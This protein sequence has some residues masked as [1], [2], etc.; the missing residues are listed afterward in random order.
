MTNPIIAAQLPTGRAPA[1]LLVQRNEAGPVTYAA[2]HCDP[3]TAIDMLR[4]ALIHVVAEHHAL[5]TVPADAVIL[6]PTP[7]P[8]SPNGAPA[9]KKPG[10]QPG[11]KR[12]RKTDVDE[13]DMQA[14]RDTWT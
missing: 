13:I 1:I 4:R 11:T 3:T 12:R 2:I 8:P 5:M 9:R 7:L 6:A 10:P 14:Q